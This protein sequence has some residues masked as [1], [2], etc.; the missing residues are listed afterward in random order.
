MLGKSSKFIGP[1]SVFQGV[2]GGTPSLVLFLDANDQLS[3][4]G[5]GEIWYDLSIRG[6]NGVFNNITPITDDIPPVSL[7][8]GG[9]SSFISFTQSDGIPIGNQ[10]YTIEVWFNSNSYGPSEQGSLVGWGTTG[11]DNAANVLRLNGN[12][13]TNY[14]WN[15]D[16]PIVFSG[17]ASMIVGNWYY[18]VASYD[19]SARKLYLNGKLFGSEGASSHNVTDSSNLQIGYFYTNYFNGKISKVKISD[20]ALSDSRILSNFNSDKVSYGYVFGSMEFNGT[21]SYLSST[22]TD[23]TFGTNDFTI[24]AFVRIAT[25]PRK[26]YDGIVSLNPSSTEIGPVIDISNTGHFEFRTSNVGGPYN[27]YTASID[28]WYHVAMSR[29]SG[30]VSCFINGDLK[31]QFYDDTDFTGQD[32]VVGRYYTDVDAHY[33]NGVISNVRVIN[34]TGLYTSSFVIPTVQLNSVSNTK[35]L[36]KSQ[37]TTPTADVSGLLQSVTASNIGW[38]S[39]LPE[40]IVRQGLEFFVDAT[41]SLSNPSNSSSNWLDISGNGR[42][43]TFSGPTFYPF[44][45]PGCAYGLIFQS[46]Q[47]AET[48]EVT[49]SYPAGYT[50]ESVVCF[51]NLSNGDGIFEFDGVANG[52]YINVQRETDGKIRFEVNQGNQLLS[53]SSTTNNLWYHITCVYNNSTQLAKIYINGV[54]DASGSFISSTSTTAPIRLG[55]HD[56]YLDG[57]ISLARFYSI[58]FTTE[59]VLLNFN[60]TKSVYGI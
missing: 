52:K 43:V 12:G 3:Y 24:E 47:I 16:F 32:L 42:N 19:G 40:F 44:C 56:Y 53:T 22:S 5:S 50:I 34:G 27:T 1:G 7:S 23:Y 2:S 49:I 48:S 38:T 59:Q 17:T 10:Q 58:P 9:T 39:S 55:I 51:S 35:F 54:E 30:T 31:N 36:I 25:M 15:N 46:N 21:N 29:N 45:R 4:N 26:L 11:V 28:T 37:Q 60:Y 18:A 33:I 13:L 57:N 6:N 14:W 20:K 41:N 8:F